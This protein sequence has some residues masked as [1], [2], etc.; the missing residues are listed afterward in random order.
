MSNESRKGFGFSSK[1]T[2][3]LWVFTMRVPLVTRS[4]PTTKAAMDRPRLT[5]Y[6]LEPGATSAFLGAAGH[7]LKPAASTR[8]A[9]AQAAHTPRRAVTNSFTAVPS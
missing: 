3:S 1:C 8:C 5:A 7:G 6:H 9:A 2:E 4:V